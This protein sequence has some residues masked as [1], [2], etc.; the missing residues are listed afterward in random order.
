MARRGR[1]PTKSIL[2]L[3]VLREL[4][5]ETP[6]KTV[7][8][9]VKRIHGISVSQSLVSRVRAQYQQERLKQ[10]AALNGQPAQPKPVDLKPLPSPGTNVV[11][12]IRLTRLAIAAA[13]GKDKLKELIDAL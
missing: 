1:Q 7:V 6:D 9:E 10:S 13:G 8:L 2:I 4:E 5:R 3:K 12:L 11:E